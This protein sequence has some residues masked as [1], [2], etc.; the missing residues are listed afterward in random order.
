LPLEQARHSEAEQVAGHGNTT[1]DC[2][3]G[4]RICVPVTS[5]DFVEEGQAH[6]AIDRP[7]SLARFSL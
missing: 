2:G 6:P 5:D 7:I 4:A 1:T 3:F